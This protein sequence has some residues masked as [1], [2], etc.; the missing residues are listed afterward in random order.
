[1]EKN[2]IDIE[3]IGNKI[4]FAGEIHKIE[5]LQKAISGYKDGIMQYEKLIE[6][7]ERD[8][9]RAEEIKLGL[10]ERNNELK[11]QGSAD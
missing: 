10:E 6:T 11:P 2:A 5:T 8:I 3:Y 4:A 1:M 9:A 7:A